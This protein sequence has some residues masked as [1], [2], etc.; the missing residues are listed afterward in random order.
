MI[1]DTLDHNYSY[2]IQFNCNHL[3]LFSYCSGPCI[4]SSRI[5]ILFNKQTTS[6]GTYKTQSNKVTGKRD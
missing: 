2:V 4:G 3:G 5:N 6:T 1:L